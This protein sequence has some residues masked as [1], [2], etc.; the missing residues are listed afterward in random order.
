MPKRF[1]IDSMIYDKIVDEAGVL[2]LV[3]RCVSSGGL[4]L[5]STH[6]QV[7]EIRQIR[8]EN[9]RDRLLAIPTAEV[10]TSGFI[11]GI[12]RLDQARLAEAEPIETLRRGNRDHTEDALIAA[13][14]SYKDAVLVTEDRTLVSRARNEHIPVITWQEFREQLDATARS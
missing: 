3:T 14:A 7:D 10:P 8:D 13:T 12:S 1:L 11:V 5:L 6:V 2:D 4:T 9:R